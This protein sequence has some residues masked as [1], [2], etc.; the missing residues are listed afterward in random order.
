MGPG[1]R[2]IV[3]RRC[4]GRGG[5][6][7][8]GGLQVA[9]VVLVVAGVVWIFLVGKPW[10]GTDAYAV[11]AAQAEG[12]LKQ[13]LDWAKDNLPKRMLPGVFLIVAGLVLFSIGAA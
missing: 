13:L 5:C 7:M 10:K 12:W 2:S 4:I 9:G 8:A 6:R 1:L 3:D 11:D